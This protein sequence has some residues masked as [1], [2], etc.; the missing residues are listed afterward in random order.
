MCAKE[1]VYCI[2]MHCL[3]ITAASLYGNGMEWK[4]KVCS[5]HMANGEWVGMPIGAEYDLFESVTSKSSLN[6]WAKSARRNKE[7]ALVEIVIFGNKLV[8]MSDIGDCYIRFTYAYANTV[9]G[10]DL[11]PKKVC[12]L[13]ACLQVPYWHPYEWDGTK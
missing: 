12:F 11:D 2:C 5:L 13:R 9:I 4:W 1:K 8:M 10:A 3:R 7:N 6:F